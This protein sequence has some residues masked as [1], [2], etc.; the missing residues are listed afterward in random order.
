MLKR[1]KGVIASLDNVDFDAK[2]DIISFQVSIMKKDTKLTSEVITG[3]YLS[4]QVKDWI[5]K[6]EVGDQL[7]VYNIK[8]KGQD[9][10][11]RELK[12]ISVLLTSE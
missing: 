4:S 6:L 7:T 1:I 5:A 11:E 9:N 10:V 2:F 3:P 12:P 8:A